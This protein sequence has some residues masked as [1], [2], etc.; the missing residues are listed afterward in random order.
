MAERTHAL[1]CLPL[2]HHVN[3]LKYVH[4]TLAVLTCYA[5]LCFAM[6]CCIALF[7]HLL[8]DRFEF[9]LDR[10]WCDYCRLLLY[11]PF[12]T[13]HS[14][15]ILH[16]INV[17]NLREFILSFVSLKQKSFFSSFSFFIRYSAGVIIISTKSYLYTFD[18]S[19][20]PPRDAF[21]T[22]HAHS[23]QPNWPEGEKKKMGPKTKRASENTTKYLHEKSTLVVTDLTSNALFVVH[24][25]HNLM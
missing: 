19:I 8:C 5:L 22:V 15:R 21:T 18:V 6:L 14:A 2:Y 17:F 12:F 7:C 4:C 25:S 13:P 23:H 10:C 24:S 16:I 1:T 9:V 11:F 20:K 3:D